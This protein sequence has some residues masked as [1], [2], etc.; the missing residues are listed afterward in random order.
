MNTT[1]NTL[2]IKETLRACAASMGCRSKEAVPHRR[3]A[4]HCINDGICAIESPREESNAA[5]DRLISSVSRGYFV[6]K[7]R[8]IRTSWQR[9]I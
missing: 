9:G 8:G 7:Q 4:N 1:I 5:Q 3:N 2:A 6:G